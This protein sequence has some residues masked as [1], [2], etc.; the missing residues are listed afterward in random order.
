MVI[1]DKCKQTILF[2]NQSAN[3]AHQVHCALEEAGGLQ[4]LVHGD[5]FQ[6]IRGQ[7]C[8]FQ[9]HPIEQNDRQQTNP[10]LLVVASC[11]LKHKGPQKAHFCPS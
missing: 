7:L 4:D 3:T 5:G 10:S 6:L 11:F 9:G 1:L 2:Q 8:L